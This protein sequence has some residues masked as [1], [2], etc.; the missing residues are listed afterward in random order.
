[1]PLSIRRNSPI[2]LFRRPGAA[3]CHIGGDQPGKKRQ[4]TPHRML[5]RYVL[6]KGGVRTALLLALV[7]SAHYTVELVTGHHEE[8]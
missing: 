3:A 6:E 5:D 2:R 8:I 1:M 4:M 7:V